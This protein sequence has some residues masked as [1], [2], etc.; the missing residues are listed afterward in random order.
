MRKHV[1]QLAYNAIRGNHCLVRLEAVHRTLVDVEDARHIAS[2]GADDLGRD[3]SRDIVLLE[4]QQFL[5]A[6]SLDRV[7]SE[8]GLLDPHPR[9]LRLKILILLTGVS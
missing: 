8:C 4:R 3:R 7:F 1:A 9:N 5:Q 2:A 6:V